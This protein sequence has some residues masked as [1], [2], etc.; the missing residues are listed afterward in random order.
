LGC[1]KNLVDSE[2]M[3]GLLEKEGF[4]VVDD[5]TVA[6]IA[7]INT[8]S[9]ISDAKKESI[10]AVLEMAE[11]RK[12]G[13]LKA[14]VVCGCLAQRYRDDILK[15]IP[16][17]DA[18]VGTTAYDEIVSAV[19]EALKANGIREFFKDKNYAPNALLPRILTTGGYYGYLKIS[20]GCDKR[21]T[22]CAIPS[23]R[24]DHRSVP[25]EMLVEDAKRLADR[26]VKELILVGQETTVY[27]K[28]LYG[29]KSLVKLLEKLEKVD[30][31]EWIR[32]LYCY[33]EEI[34]DDL[35]DAIAASKKICRY[36]DMPIQHASDD[37][38]KR[39]G[40]RTDRAHLEELIDK[41]R[42]KIPGV[43]LRTS[44]IAGFPGETEKDHEIMLDFV[45]QA[46]FDRLGVFTYSKEEDTPA[47]KMPDQVPARIKTKRR[48]EIMLLQQKIA[49]DL[50]K[51]RVGETYRVMIEGRID[52]DVYAARTYMDAPGVDGYVFLKSN[53][54][55]MSG[56]F[57]DIR[58]TAAKD[59]D[60]IGEEIDPERN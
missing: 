22:Y 46:R 12:S 3:I 20:E 33:P 30:G 53:R 40:R 35:I 6:D 13:E 11:R 2:V 29:G 8:C 57:T 42:K 32:L 18:V 47:A 25:M 17:I 5:E 51:S 52:P 44:L 41:L 34:E 56:S 16:E 21:C 24:G 4:E 9:F 10:N 31:I 14:L 45:K 55:Y 15:E 54:D 23:M 49:F 39:M 7:V 27:G 37:I 26:G 36:L 48:K 60:L 28:D 38:L 58:V 59:Y 43:A 50:A 19:K 1:D